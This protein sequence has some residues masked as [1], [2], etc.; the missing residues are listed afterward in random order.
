MILFCRDDRGRDS[1]RD[2]RDDRSDYR[3]GGYRDSRDYRGG[4]YR[5]GDYRGG[6]GYGGGGGG[7][8]GRY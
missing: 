2:R 1:Y 5:G 6:G 7:Y 3:G 8:R 4:D